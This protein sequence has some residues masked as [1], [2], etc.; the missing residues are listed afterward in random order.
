MLLYEL[1]TNRGHSR[2]NI[3]V[4]PTVSDLKFARFEVAMDNAL[5]VR[6]LQGVR[7]LHRVLQCLAEW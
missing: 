2:A 3:N 1:R 7:D 6:R 5:R 4:V